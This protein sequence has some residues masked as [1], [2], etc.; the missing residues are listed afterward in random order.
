MEPEHEVESVDPGVM[1]M[2]VIQSLENKVNC[3]MFNPHD[4]SC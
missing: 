4:Y 3:H 1:E 2:S